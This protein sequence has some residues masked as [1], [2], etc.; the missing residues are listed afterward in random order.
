V[1][2]FKAHG[3]VCK[4]ISTGKMADGKASVYVQPTLVASTEPEANVPMN[5]N[6][7]TL[8]GEFS[9]RMSSVQSCFP[10]VVK[11]SLRRMWIV[12]CRIFL[13]A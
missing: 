12:Q 11:E 9:Q 4:L 5:Y 3:L 8:E 13:W 7:I 1:E 2:N 10:S 6:L